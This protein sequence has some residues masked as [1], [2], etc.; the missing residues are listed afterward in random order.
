[1]TLGKWKQVARSLGITI[2]GKSNLD[3]DPTD[4]FDTSQTD[5]WQTTVDVKTIAD[6]VSVLQ[7]SLNTVQVT[8]DAANSLA[9]TNATSIGEINTSLTTVQG[10]ADAA[11][12][13]AT[14]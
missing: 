11:N 7:T 2:N 5:D 4:I 3:I 13:L 14:A 1:M 12:S 9:T 8:A 6:D 10:T